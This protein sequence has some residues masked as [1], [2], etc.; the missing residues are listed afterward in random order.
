MTRRVEVAGCDKRSATWAPAQSQEHGRQPTATLRRG[1]M[2]AL[3]STLPPLDEGVCLF[4]G[5]AHL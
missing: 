4:P 1:G 3:D 5:Q 2:Q